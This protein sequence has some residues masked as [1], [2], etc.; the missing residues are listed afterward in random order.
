MN[1]RPS[2]VQGAVAMQDGNDAPMSVPLLAPVEAAIAMTSKA[3]RAKGILMAVTTGIDDVELVGLPDNLTEAIAELLA[4]VI[5]RSPQQGVV[6]IDVRPGTRALTLVAIDQGAMPS[7]K[8]EA[9]R[10]FKHLWNAHYG[11]AHGLHINVRSDHRSRP[12]PHE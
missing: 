4:Y 10:P 3:A 5:E 9:H 6:T 12:D 2:P 7:P 1:D 11:T 8:D